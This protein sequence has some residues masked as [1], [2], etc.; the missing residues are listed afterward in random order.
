M[1]LHI[2]VLLCVCGFQGVGKDTFS[3]YLVSNYKFVKFSFASATKDIL[4]IL[5][6]WDRK[7]LEGDTKESREFREQVDLWWSEKL[8]ILNLTPRKALQLVGTDLFRKHFNP[9]IWVKVVE[10]KILK[11]LALKPNSNIIV[12]DCRFP[13]EIQM[14]KNL[15]FKLVHIQRNL[16]TWFDKYKSGIDCE[17]VAELHES[18]ISWIREDFDHTIINNFETKELFELEINKLFF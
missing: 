3:D 12:S 2:M 5:F 1:I 8:G 18:E 13:N 15:K 17:E 16:P 4:S 7:M 9:E 10:K 14:L 6:G 11:Q